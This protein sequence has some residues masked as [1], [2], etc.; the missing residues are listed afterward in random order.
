MWELGKAFPDADTLVALSQ[1]FNVTTDYLLSNTGVIPNEEETPVTPTPKEKQI[2]KINKEL[3]HLNPK[4]LKL[5][6][7]LVR[8]ISH[9]DSE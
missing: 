6:N 1:L 8:E 5:V 4:Q 9:R 3:T 2:G 7:D